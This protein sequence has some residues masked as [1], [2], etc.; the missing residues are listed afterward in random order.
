MKLTFEEFRLANIARC[1]KW[2]PKGIESWSASDWMTAITGELGEAAGVLKMMNRERDGL[3]GNK[4]KP[5]KEMLAKELADV[6][7]YL[8]L[9]AAREGIDLGLAVVQKFNEVSVRVGFPDRL[10]T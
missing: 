8:D 6:F 5:T 4:I 1:L 2:H 3:P 9:L 10:P 7:I